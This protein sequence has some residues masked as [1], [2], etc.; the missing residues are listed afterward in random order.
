M[1][2]VMGQPRYGSIHSPAQDHPLAAQ[3]GARNFDAGHFPSG[4][5]AQRVLTELRKLAKHMASPTAE[6]ATPVRS[7]LDDLRARRAAHRRPG[8]R[9]SPAVGG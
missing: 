1:A 9:A 5:A 2:A 3:P 4:G 8:L 6:A 7:A